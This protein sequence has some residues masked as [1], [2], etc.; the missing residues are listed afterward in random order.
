MYREAIVALEADVIGLQEVDQGMAR[1]G[2][3]DMTGE[4]AD[5]I[6][7]NGFFAAARRRWDL[8][9]Y[10]NALLST[11][12]IHDARVLRYE[13]A[14]VRCERRVAAIATVQV[15]GQRWHIA[16][17]HLSLRAD[18]NVNQLKAV[19]NELASEPEP[20][21]LMGDFNMSPE[22]VRHTLE[23]LGW[24]VLD[25]GF[26]FPSWSPDHTIDF[27]CVQG[28]TAE[29]VE[30]RSMQVSDHAALLATLRLN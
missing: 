24:E 21:V 30:V 28:A 18:E 19:A 12:T 11:G 9:K 23:P 27:I 5:A 2:R 20:R 25:S 15:G 7:G 4:A 17:T 3:A 8:G 16:N 6:G 14:N 29:M 22:V 13:R 10:G 26:T 1:S